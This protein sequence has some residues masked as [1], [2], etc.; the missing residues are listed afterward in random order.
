MKAI[1]SAAEMTRADKYTIDQGLSGELLME[2]AAQAC[3]DELMPHLGQREHIA[4]FCGGGNN[5]GDGFAMAR[6]LHQS[7][8][9][10]HVH[11]LKDEVKDEAAHHFKIL[12]ESN[13]PRNLIDHTRGFEIPSTVT[14]IIDALVGVGLKSALKGPVIELIHQINQHRAPVLSVDMPS[15]LCADHGELMGEHVVARLTVT[16][17]TLKFAHVITPAC[18]ACGD[19][20]TRDIGIRFP[21]SHQQKAFALQ[22]TDYHRDPRPPNSHKGTF[23]SLAVVGG[24]PGMEGAANLTAMAALRFGAGKVT[25]MSPHPGSG[26]FHHDSVMTGSEKRLDAFS[27]VVIGP[28][29]SRGQLAQEW[30][31]NTTLGRAR[32][33]W[34]ADGLALL[35][36]RPKDRGRQFVVTPHPGEAAQLLG[37]QGQEIQARRLASSHALRQMFPDTWIVLKGFR[38]IISAPDGSIY[39]CTPGNAALATAGSGDVLAGMIGAMLAQSEC[40]TQD[41]VLLSVL[42]HA[43]SAEH[44]LEQHADHAMLAEDIVEDLKRLI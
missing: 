20:V 6:I 13:C 10:V 16:F 36:N 22:R 9:K 24:F 38:T 32:V 1:V 43:L 30:L 34:D 18:L 35:A 12:C 7:G 41:A 14:W 33:V 21:D 29:L 37:L 17:Q 28:G 42:R 40:A 19:I 15:G 27:A 31:A 26:R 11:Y 44:W 5:G 39:V 4:V 2:R 23:G 25:I 3:V 8:F